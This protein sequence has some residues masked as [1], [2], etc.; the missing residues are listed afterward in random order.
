MV[1]NPNNLPKVHP[2]E[3]ADGAARRLEILL[4]TLDGPM[5]VSNA[6]VPREAND[7]GDVD[8]RPNPRACHLGYPEGY[9]CAVEHEVVPSRGV[10]TTESE[11]E[12]SDE[13]GRVVM[14]DPPNWALAGDTYMHADEEDFIEDVADWA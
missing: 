9:E 12:G 4:R 10:G 14:S 1:D 2:I 8:E 7:I 6:L 11:S 5:S 13:G 3:K